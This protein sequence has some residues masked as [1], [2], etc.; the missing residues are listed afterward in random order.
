MLDTYEKHARTKLAAT[1]VAVL[2]IAGIVVLADHIKSKPTAAMAQTTS[3][4]A[5]S[6]QP[7]SGTPSGSGS[8]SSNSSGTGTYKDG[9]YTASSDYFVPPG[10]ETI[11]VS[12]TLQNGVV[13]GSSIKNSENDRTSAEFQQA[14]AAEYKAFVVG[15]K[16]SDLK[17]GIVAGASDTTQGFNDAV[18]Q[19]AS[20]A[21]N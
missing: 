16:V 15:K 4:G 6:A 21:Q 5:T 18:N 10:D 11:E 8:T 1:I 19:I 20:K 12:L 17:L 13:T 2:V 7:S 3:T 9:T 14:F